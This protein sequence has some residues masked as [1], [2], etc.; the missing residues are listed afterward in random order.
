MSALLPPEGFNTKFSVPTVELRPGFW[1]RLALRNRPKLLDWDGRPGETRF[2]SGEGGYEILYL[3]SDKMTAFWEVFGG[4]LLPLV[5][6]D[7]VLP[8]AVMAQ[9]HWVAFDVPPVFGVF[10]ATRISAVREVGGSNMS[11]HGD[12]SVSQTW[13]RA[14]WHHPAAIDGI[15]YRSD[16]NALPCVALFH[17]RHQ[18]HLVI[19]AKSH[20]L[21]A[22]DG[23]FLTALRRKG[24]FAAGPEPR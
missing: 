5:P 14:L 15:L 9:R 2:V 13:G 7:R 1:W 20:G 22:D 8:P 19:K 3:A 24:R 18:K 4:R 10:N 21:L 23:A 17:R 16:K 11:F 12:W 6:E